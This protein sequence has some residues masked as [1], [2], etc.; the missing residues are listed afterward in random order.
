MA[1]H[2]AVELPRPFWLLLEGLVSNTYNP[3][4]TNQVLLYILILSANESK[5]ISF[6]M[7]DDVVLKEASFL[8]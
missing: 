8:C 2:S 5:A 7:Y 3:N 1:L 6:D 4:Y